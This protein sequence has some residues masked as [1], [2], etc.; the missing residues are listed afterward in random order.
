[1][2]NYKGREFAL[3]NA[4]RDCANLSVEQLRKS[5]DVLME[6]DNILKST[7]T[8]KKLVLEE[9]MVKLLLVSKEVSYD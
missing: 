3:R 1:Y 4:M 6:A 7:G 9:T 8:D 2:Y 5:L